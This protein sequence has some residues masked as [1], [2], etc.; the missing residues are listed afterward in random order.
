VREE[1]RKFWQEWELTSAFQRALRRHVSALLKTLLEEGGSADLDQSGIMTRAVREEIITA[2]EWYSRG[3]WRSYDGFLRWNNKECL[4]ET[5]RVVAEVTPAKF[6][7]AL[8]EEALEYESMGWEVDIQRLIECAE[9]W[10]AEAIKAKS[11]IARILAGMK[12]H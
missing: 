2:M 4:S 8:V 12:S 6:R 10:E 5:P 11:Q 3:L 9:E 1:D 7:R